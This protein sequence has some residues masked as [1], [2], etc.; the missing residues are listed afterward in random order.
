MD[1]SDLGE[2]I[3]DRKKPLA[4][5]TL[6]KIEAGL[7]MFAEP[8]MITLTHGATSDGRPYPAAAIPDPHRETRRRDRHPSGIFG[9]LRRLC[10]PGGLDAQGRFGFGCGCWGSIRAC[11]RAGRGS[12]CPQRWVSRRSRVLSGGRLRSRGGGSGDG[13]G[14][15]LDRG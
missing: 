6:R 11:R 4:A 8:T 9:A 3:G 14:C 2:R 5:N 1:W 12:R 7:A 10:L 13:P 15:D